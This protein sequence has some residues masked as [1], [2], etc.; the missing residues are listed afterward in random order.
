MIRISTDMQNE[1]ARVVWHPQ[2]TEKIRHALVPWCQRADPGRVPVQSIT[3]IKL[4]GGHT[5]P[6]FSSK[7]D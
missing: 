2:Q 7:G 4:S 3:A 5:A 6:P 1:S